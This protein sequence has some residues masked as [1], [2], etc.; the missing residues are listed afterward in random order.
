MLSGIKGFMPVELQETR[1]YRGLN[2]NTTFISRLKP[3]SPGE[4][5][6]HPVKTVFH[7]VN[8]TILRGMVGQKGVMTGDNGV[9]TIGP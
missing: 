9:I 3:A 6:Y 7:R 5:R 1:G 4:N 8:P 2:R